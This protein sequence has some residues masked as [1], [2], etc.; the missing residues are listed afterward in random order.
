MSPATQVPGLAAPPGGVIG[1][2]RREE[3][4]YR[5]GSQSASGAVVGLDRVLVG[6][7]LARLVGVLVGRVDRLLAGCRLRLRP[8]PGSSPD[9]CNSPVSF[10]FL[11]LSATKVMYVASHVRTTVRLTA[12]GGRERA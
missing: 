5:R 8:L 12:S 7:R 4:P 6:G 11:A 1:A 3:L 2:G 9:G 10:S